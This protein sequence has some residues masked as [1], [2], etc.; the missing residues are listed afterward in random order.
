MKAS[1]RGFGVRWTEATI[2]GAGIALDLANRRYVVTVVLKGPDEKEIR[3]ELTRGEVA[4]I[5]KADE[6]RRNYE[7]QYFPEG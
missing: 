7:A 6:A 5:I 1:V 3:L 2:D 4:K